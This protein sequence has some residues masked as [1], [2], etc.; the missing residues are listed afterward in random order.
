MLFAV[1]APRETIATTRP[2][3]DLAIEPRIVR[4]PD[5][6]AQ[7]VGVCLGESVVRERLDAEAIEED[8]CVRRAVGN[9]LSWSCPMIASGRCMP[10]E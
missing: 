6:P 8:L 3:R 9:R 5:P 1:V 10:A 2:V 4:H 7:F